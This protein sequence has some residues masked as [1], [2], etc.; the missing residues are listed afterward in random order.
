MEHKELIKTISKVADKVL[1]YL[2]KWNLGT[3]E[4]WAIVMD[5]EYVNK[6]CPHTGK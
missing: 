5:F 2:E 6:I 1:A 4:K 3:R